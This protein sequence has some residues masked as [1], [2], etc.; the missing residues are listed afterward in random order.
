[1]SNQRLRTPS[2][3]QLAGTSE[4]HPARSRVTGC[5]DTRGMRY[6]AAAQVKGSHPKE[7]WI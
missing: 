1:M 7:E 2:R 4:Q 3:I 5:H 6:R